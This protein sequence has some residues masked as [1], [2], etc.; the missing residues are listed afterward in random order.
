MYN[1]SSFFNR[2]FHF[3]WILLRNSKRIVSRINYRLRFRRTLCQSVDS[4]GFPSIDTILSQENRTDCLNRLKSFKLISPRQK[5]PESSKKAAVL[6]PLCVVNEELGLLYTLRRS[7]LK[8]HRGQVSFPGGVRD[9]TDASLVETALRETEEELGIDRKTVD[10]WGVSSFVVGME[11]TVLPVVGCVGTIE[12]KDLK[13]NPDEV[14]LPF[15]VPLKHF[16][17]LDN[18]RYTQFRYGSKGYTLPAYINARCR[19]WGITALIT[20]LVLMSLLPKNYLH[21]I[22]HIKPVLY[23]DPVL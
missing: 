1:F 11:F 13:P 20:H 2:K 8:R 6:V 5:P 23:K 16:C 14:E 10:V 12:I 7:D 21:R 22:N 17:S 19:I 9:E 15:V 4:S 18:C 3:E